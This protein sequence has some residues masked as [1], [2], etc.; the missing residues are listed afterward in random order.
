MADLVRLPDVAIATLR[1]RERVLG[2][3][4]AGK[5]V[6]VGSDRIVAVGPDEWLVIADDGDAGVL[7]DRIGRYRGSVVDSSGNRVCYR[8]AGDRARWLLSAGCSFDL[9][10]LKPDDAIST[11]FARAQV[12][13]V[14]EA[15]NSF[16]VLPRRS[17]ASYLKA[18]AAT[19]D[20]RAVA[21][22]GVALCRRAGDH[23]GSYRI[24]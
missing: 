7:C 15:E 22:A 18:W 2:L 24:C 20:D 23:D 14:A 16:L 11:M 4:M 3:P 12:I 6:V 9:D 10:R 21:N 5:S 19:L 8:V 13:I 1:L 17:F